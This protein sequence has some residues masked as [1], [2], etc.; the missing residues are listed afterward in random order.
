MAMQPHPAGHHH[1]HHHGHGA[2]SQTRLT[3]A[4][5]LTLAFAA[6]E[7]LGGW[8]SGSL[9]LLGDAGHM[10]TDATALALAAV[11]A[12]IARK[13]PSA[14]HTFGLGRAEVIAA[15]VNGL[16]ML[17]IVIAI[18]VTA[19]DRLRSPQPVTAG[20]VMLVAALGLM[21]NVLVALRLSHGERTLNTRA[22][23]LHV[24]GDLL[25]SVATLIAGAVIWFTGWT[26]IDPILS[27]FICALILF[28]SVRLLRDALHVIMEGA[29]AEI[30]TAEVGGAMAGVRGVLSVHDLHV[31]TL[32]SGRIALSS[33]VVVPHFNDWDKTLA[34]LR[35][36]LHR[37]F[38]IDHVT[39]QPELDVAVGA[40][41]GA[42][43]PGE[44]CHPCAETPAYTG[45][46]GK[47]RSAW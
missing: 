46:D 26:P 35:E 24:V 44:H 31:W 1:G 13:P 14:R 17:L 42:A 47:S 37:R 40:T 9:A 7:A 27:L 22:A 21:V 39:L 29:P 3:Q 2:D 19:V 5:A 10:V 11:A 41:P 8:W 38:D 4:V 34:T 6:V 33:H 20:V 45:Q 36:L 15:L 25:G 23:L 28:G 16:F 43:A 18:V 32:S 12:W 30:D